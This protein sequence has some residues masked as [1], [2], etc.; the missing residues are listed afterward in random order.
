MKYLAKTAGQ[1]RNRYLDFVIDPSFQG[2]NRLFV[3]SFKDNDGRES[4][5]QY[6]LQAV[7]I[8]DYYVIIVG[9]NF[10]DQPI[11]N[12][13]KTYDNI[14]KITTGQG[15]DYTTG[16][17]LDYT[18]FKKYYKLIAIYLSKQQKL[19]ADPKAIQ[20]INFTGNLDRAGASIMFFII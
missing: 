1:G 10:F 20:Q 11:K 8:K 17:L 18:Y 14:R 4:D 16:C 2:V 9:R 15:D 13:L 19:D 7:K 6:Y 5:K 12:D 3:L